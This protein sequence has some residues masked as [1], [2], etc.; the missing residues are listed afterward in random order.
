[1]WELHQIQQRRMNRKITRAQAIMKEVAGG[2][3]CKFFKDFNLWRLL[4]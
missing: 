1:L 4:E 2:R 3:H